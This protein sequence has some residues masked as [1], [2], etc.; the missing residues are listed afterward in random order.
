MTTLP[1]HSS[2]RAK[3]TVPSPTPQATSPSA[4]PR[5]PLSPPDSMA[6]PPAL[7]Q[8][9]ASLSTSSEVE[10]E[11]VEGQGPPPSRRVSFSDEDIIPRTRFAAIEGLT[12]IA[13]FFVFLR[14]ATVNPHYA[15]G[16]DVALA[17]IAFMVTWGMLRKINKPFEAL[18]NTYDARLKHIYPGLLLLIIVTLLMVKIFGTS[19][20]FGQ[21][22]L[23][24]FTGLLGISNIQIIMSY[25][26]AMSNPGI[27]DALYNLWAVSLMLQ[28]FVVW[29]LIIALTARFTRSS[30]V[31]ILTVSLILFAASAAVMPLMWDGLNERRLLAGTDSRV[32]CMI[33]GAIAATTRFMYEKNRNRRVLTGRHRRTSIKQRYWLWTTTGIAA[34]GVIVMFSARFYWFNAAWLFQGGYIFLTFFIGLLLLS[35]SSQQNLLTRFFSFSLFTGMGRISFILYMIHYPILWLFR[36]VMTTPATG[37]QVT[38]VAGLITLVLG[39]LIYLFLLTPARST[40]WKLSLVI[41]IIAATIAF[42]VVSGMPFFRFMLT[43]LPP[44]PF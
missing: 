4:S 30:L 7:S 36:K 5:L 6:A 13:M 28:F 22:L 10:E 35:L 39:A 31:A 21:S 42:F 1:S 14:N 32:L 16:L 34:L 12:G 44:Y 17:G 27:S 9:A 29:P 26:P 40:Q 37:W 15:F 3:G 2:T 24:G 43:E 18:D 20:D 8:V 33:A 41:P 38:L 25:Q 23:T 19:A 11:I